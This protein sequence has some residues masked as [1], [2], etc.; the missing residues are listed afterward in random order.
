M[1]RV[2]GANELQNPQPNRPEAGSTSHGA[3]LWVKIELAQRLL[4][5]AAQRFWSS[6]KIQ[7]LFPAFLL[8]LYSLVSCSVPL[9]TAACERA[10]RLAAGDPLAAKTA[11][12]LK[13]HIEEETHHDEWLLDDLVASGMD[14]RSVLHRWP[15][16]NIASLVG[17]QY[18]WIRH[19]HPAALFGYLALI[20]GNPPLAEHL[21]QIQLLTG[22]PPESFRCLHQ[23]A[24]D[25]A[26]HLKELRTTIAELPLKAEDESLI[27]MSV[28]ATLAGLIRILEDL[29]ASVEPVLSMKE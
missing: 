4:N 23:H 17:S 2:A 24:A 13:R 12:Y 20:E 29:V 11:E 27:A 26:E 18:C 9:M 8:E 6:G 1:S 21:N 15:G 22:Y 19:A 25:D 28:F 10:S 16:A 7:Q 14:R 3:L 5:I